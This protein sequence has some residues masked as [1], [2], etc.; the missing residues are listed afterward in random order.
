MSFVT[1]CDSLGGVGRE[2]SPLWNIRHIG[3]EAK[4]DYFTK[5]CQMLHGMPKTGVQG[6]SA[7]SQAQRLNIIHCRIEQFKEMETNAAIRATKPDPVYTPQPTY[8]PQNQGPIQ[9]PYNPAPQ[10]PR[11]FRCRTYGQN[12]TCNEW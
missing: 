9:Q 5:K 2:G 12:T 8:N 3:G 11:Q 1:G 10:M 6:L 4:L 7:L